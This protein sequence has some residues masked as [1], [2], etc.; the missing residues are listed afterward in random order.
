M[1]GQDFQWIHYLNILSAFPASGGNVYAEQIWSINGQFSILMFAS[2]MQF[3]KW[4]SLSGTTEQS[5]NFCLEE[6]LKVLLLHC[7]ITTLLHYFSLRSTRETIWKWGP[8]EVNFIPEYVLTST[9]QDVNYTVYFS[10]KIVW[11]ELFTFM[12]SRRQTE[13]LCV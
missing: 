9:F 6:L 1:A 7:C 12:A 11:F 5:E 4:N 13:S 10:P 3:H 2:S 8:N